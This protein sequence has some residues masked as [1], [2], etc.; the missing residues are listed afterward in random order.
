MTG[1]DTASRSTWLALSAAV[2]CGML[3]SLQQ[4]I[5]GELGV[6]LTDAVLAALVSFA[7]GLV[8]VSVVVLARADARQALARVTD[9]PWWQR[10]GGLGGASLVAT[11]A[12]AAPRLG[13]ALSTVGIVG[14][15]VVGG[16]AVDRLG[17]GPG[18]MR[19]L[20]G[21]RLAG[22][23][24][25][26]VAVGLSVTGGG[27]RSADPLLLVAVVVAGLLVSLQ[28]A[29]NGRVR[30]STGQASVATLVN[31][32]GGT[33][34]LGALVAARAVVG[35]LGPVSWPGTWYL[36]TGGVVS[37]LFVATAALVVRTV[38]VL[39]LAMA[40][41]AGQVVGGLV[42]DLVL[43]ATGAD[44]QLTTFLAIALTLTALAVSSRTA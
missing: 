36:Y 22:G 16:L 40:V 25:C 15:Q 24:L 31:F 11:G 37:T 6:R 5:N 3:V 19:H 28:Q 7:V 17:V 44:L 10:L 39:R 32:V 26:V 30:E 21:P 33:A 38:G 8:C 29:V 12:A 41:S 4:R 34:V 35:D 23:L 1:S 14:G 27:A 20:T 42:L 2:V 43:P 18:G 9:V 13:I